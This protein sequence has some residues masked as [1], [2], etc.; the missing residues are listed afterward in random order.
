MT[1]LECPIM[2][3]PDSLQL[4]RDTL[5]PSALRKALPKS[6]RVVD[7][8]LTPYTD[9]LGD[10]ALSVDV[11]LDESTSEDE[12]TWR[13]LEPIER[14]IQQRVLASGVSLFPYTRYVK[15]SEIVS[16]AVA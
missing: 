5:K 7:I 14:L 9:S 2:G 11:L 8:K 6:P 16:G 12:R 10:A 3:M 1:V 4:L 15:Q 13:K